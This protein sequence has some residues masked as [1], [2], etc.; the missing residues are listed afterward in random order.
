MLAVSIQSC[1][2]DKNGIYLIYKT[3]MPPTIG[4]SSR[5][6]NFSAS[7]NLRQIFKGKRLAIKFQP[8]YVIIQEAHSS[9]DLVLDKVGEQTDSN[10][11]YELH[12]NK[13]RERF[14]LRLIIHKPLDQP[15]QISLTI[16]VYQL[17]PDERGQLIKGDYAMAIC[18]LDKVNDV[19]SN[20]ALS[21]RKL[22]K[23][24]SEQPKVTP[25]IEQEQTTQPPTPVIDYNAP[26][27]TVLDTV[28]GE[29]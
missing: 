22:D 2:E 21:F 8:N 6:H 24:F 11:S 17:T 13:G 18:Q 15:E 27:S 23:F 28:I 3:E 20:S 9:E 19:D 1:K 29:Y 14:E 7:E 26:D 25:I 4:L 16:V 12:Y 5:G 10:K